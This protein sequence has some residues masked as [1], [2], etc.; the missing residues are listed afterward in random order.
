MSVLISLFAGCSGQPSDGS[1]SPSN[2]DG[3]IATYRFGETATWDDGT[4]IKV[5]APEVITPS[6]YVEVP[7]GWSA[8]RFEVT[9]VNNSGDTMQFL[10]RSF[11]TSGGVDGEAFLDAGSDIKWPSDPYIP[12]GESV[13]FLIGFTAQNPEDVELQVSPDLGLNYGKVAFTF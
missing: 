4:T 11:L 3:V 1:N 13:T 9:M 10:F 2:G 8:L 5:S 6:S 12:N 7:E